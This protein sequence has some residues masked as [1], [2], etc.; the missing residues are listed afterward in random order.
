MKPIPDT[1]NTK[2]SSSDIIEVARAVRFAI[3]VILFGLSY[4]SIRISFGLGG[5][6]QVLD[7]MGIA[8]PAITS[9]IITAR[10]A[11]M[12]ASVLIPLAALGCF[13]DSNVAR[14]IYNLGRL[15]LLVIIQLIL[16]YHGFSAPLVK[17]VTSVTAI[18]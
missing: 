6:E 11:L 16:F 10:P 3:A 9:F 12:F 18:N 17:M 2:Q 14:S 1:D 8:L 7:G 15:C 4:V 5:I 13:L